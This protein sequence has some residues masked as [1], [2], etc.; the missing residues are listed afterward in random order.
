MVGRLPRKAIDFKPLSAKALDPMLVTLEGTVTLVSL[1]QLENAES[2][3]LVTLVGIVTL[4]SPLSSPMSSTHMRARTAWT[5]LGA[6]HA[7]AHEGRPAIHGDHTGRAGAGGC[8]AGTA[9]VGAG[10]DADAAA[11]GAEKPLPGRPR[12]G[13]CAGRLSG[14]AGGAAAAAGLARARKGSSARE[15]AMAASSWS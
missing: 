9:G 15:A 13:E 6:G 10:L 2:A 11:T 5:S 12:A 14:G 4:V 3:M 1:T 8:V 7:A